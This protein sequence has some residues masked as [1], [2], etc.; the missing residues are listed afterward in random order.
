M[1]TT[2]DRVGVKSCI[3]CGPNLWSADGTS[4]T[5]NGSFVLPNP[6]NTT[7]RYN[8]S[9]LASRFD[10]FFVP[11]F[12]RFCVFRSIIAFGKLE[13]VQ[14]I[15]LLI[16]FLDLAT[17]FLTCFARFSSSMTKKFPAHLCFAVCEFTWAILAERNWLCDQPRRLRIELKGYSCSL[18]LCGLNFLLWF[19]L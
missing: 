2:S 5:T 8:L 11:F 13:H 12:R 17:H 15:V 3:P 16:K 19:F 9:A 1:N 14:N 18:L 10:F 7:S 4:C 6:D